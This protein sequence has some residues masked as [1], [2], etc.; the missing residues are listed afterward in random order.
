MHASRTSLFRRPKPPS[1]RRVHA[2][3]ARPREL[4]H[5]L[6]QACEIWRQ[7]LVRRAGYERGQVRRSWRHGA[8][9]LFSVAATSPRLVHATM[10]RRKPWDSSR[11]SAKAPELRCINRQT[12]GDG[13]QASTRTRCGQDVQCVSDQPLH[14]RASSHRPFRLQIPAPLQLVHVYTPTT[15]TAEPNR[16]DAAR[17]AELNA[18]KQR[19]AD[20]AKKSH[21]AASSKRLPS[22]ICRRRRIRARTRRCR[23]PLR[24]TRRSK[25]AAS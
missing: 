11:R 9:P 13:L 21:A 16:E 8:G 19:N 22:R 25:T 20:K 23:F 2:Y 24:S 10:P 15:S 1:R 12:E 6:S 3:A 7:G 4:S 14:D 18:C 17:T 5:A